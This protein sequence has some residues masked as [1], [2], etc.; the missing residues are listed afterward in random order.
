MSK[1]KERQDAMKETLILIKQ[2]DKLQADYLKQ[3]GIKS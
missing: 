1:T 2:I 3:R